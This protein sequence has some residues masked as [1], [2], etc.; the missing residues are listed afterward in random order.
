M[1]KSKTVQAIFSFLQKPIFNKTVR[2]LLARAIFKN[3]P[4]NKLA[5]K[6]KSLAKGNITYLAPKVT[7]STSSLIAVGV[8]IKDTAQGEV[9]SLVPASAQGKTIS[10]KTTEKVAR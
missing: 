10:V 6:A 4:T 2:L 7:A 1:A 3:K 5:N 9:R 8:D